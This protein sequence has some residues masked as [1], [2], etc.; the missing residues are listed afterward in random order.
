M[1]RLLIF[2][3]GILPLFSYGQTGPSTPEKLYKTAFLHIINSPEIKEWNQPCVIV[4]DSLVSFP[5]SI[6]TEQLAKRWGYSSYQKERLLLDS[7]ITLEQATPHRA[8]HF[9]F[10]TNLTKLPGAEKGCL[11]VMFS[12]LD[13]DVLLAEVSDIEAYPLAR[14][15]IISDFD[16]SV[17]YLLFFDRDGRVQRCYTRSLSYN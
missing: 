14:R 1:K 3:L 6:F 16:K 17:L 9:P 15:N 2:T 12:Q 5:Q 7:L 10:S 4:F 11:A 8:T 13:N